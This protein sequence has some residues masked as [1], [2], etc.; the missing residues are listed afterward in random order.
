[1]Y[2]D[3]MEEVPLN[4][5]DEQFTKSQ[6]EEIWEIAHPILSTIKNIFS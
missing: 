2:V 1:M 4:I 5:K 3:W 6:K